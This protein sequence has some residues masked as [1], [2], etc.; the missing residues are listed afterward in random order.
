M[1]RDEASDRMR[2]LILLAQSRDASLA[3]IEI[4]NPF[5]WIPVAEKRLGVKPDSPVPTR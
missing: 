3:F 2:E 4:R 5:D 1:T